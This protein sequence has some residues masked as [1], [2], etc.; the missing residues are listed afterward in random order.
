MLPDV[1]P[2]NKRK[3]GMERKNRFAALIAAAALLLAGCGDQPSPPAETITLPPQT[4]QTTQTQT[5]TETE[6]SD[7]PET[8]TAAEVTAVSPADITAEV[9]GKVEMSSLAEVG[10]D[11]L[12][13]YLEADMDKVESFSMFICGSGGFADEVAVFVMKDEDSTGALVDSMKA[14]IDSRAVDFKDYNPDEYD[15]LK[16]ALVK[17]KGRYVFMA[18]TGDNDTAESIFDK[19]TD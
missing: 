3:N 11:R 2:M 14:R 4:E 18:V 9:I 6:T 17:T 8:E 10:E 16:H 1:S 5:Q 15:K 19:Y 13:N 7:A 12:G